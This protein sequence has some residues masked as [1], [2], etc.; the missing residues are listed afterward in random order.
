MNIVSAPGSGKTTVAAERFGYLRHKPT[1]DRRGVIGIS[2]TRSAAA[3][4]S[5]R[6]MSRWGSSALCFPHIVSTFDEFHV[7][8]LHN[9]LA[10]GGIRWPAGLTELTVIDEYR[11]LPGFR[12]LAAGGYRRAALVNANR[13]VYSGSVRVTQPRSGIGNVSQHREHLSNGIVSHE[14]VRSVLLSAFGD[15]GLVTWIEAWIKACYRALIIDEIYDADPLDLS[16]AGMSAIAGLD[17]TLIGDPW[18]A[19][20]GWRGAT[21]ERVAYLLTATPFVH[22]ELPESFRF[23]GEQMPAL[24]ENLRAGLPVSIPIVSSTN[25]DVALARRWRDLWQVGD[26]ILPLAFR[27]VGNGIDAMLNILLDHVTRSCLGRR[28]FGLQAA[29]V[30]LGLDEL[31]FSERQPA[32]ITPIVEQLVAGRPAVEVLGLLR[33]AAVTFGARRRPNRLR[34][35]SELIRQ[36]ELEALQRRLGRRDLIPGLTVHQAK[37]CEWQRV[38]VALRSADLRRLSEGLHELEPEDCVLYVALTR[39]RR[40]CGRLDDSAQLPKE[41]GEA[42]DVSGA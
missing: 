27:T 9:L 33:D 29:C 20:Y 37:G 31:S 24:A 1:M 6:I 40:A 8:L 35:E 41:A 14:D 21:P 36:L 28:A 17:V 12:W 42:A 22:Y 38:G 5:S 30:Q 34:E 32:I 16:I 7:R 25:V 3:E 13:E 2:F 10:A 39:A 23:E 15:P 18:Q 4:L 26:N 11:G 19:L